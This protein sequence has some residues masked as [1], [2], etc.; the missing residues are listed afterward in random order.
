VYR[1]A[2]INCSAYITVGTSESGDQLVVRQMSDNHNHTI[3]PE[4]YK[5]YKENRKL[6]TDSKATAALML[7]MG[8]NATKVQHHLMA[9]TQK[10]VTQQDVQ[11]IRN[12][13]HARDGQTDDVTRVVKMLKR[14]DDATVRLVCNDDGTVQSL[15]YQMPFMKQMFD[16][17]QET[18]IF[19]ATYKINNRSMLLFLPLVIDSAGYSQIVAVILTADEKAETLRSAI[20]EFGDLTGKLCEVKCLVVDKDMSAI[21]VLQSVY[22]CSCQSLSVA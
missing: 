2:K 17:F 9:T 7:N 4:A 16:T 18:I 1:S 20:A 10:V 19:D 13:F 14:N 22:K 5:H 21:D 12:T 11:N 3:V 8:A 15:L 6:D